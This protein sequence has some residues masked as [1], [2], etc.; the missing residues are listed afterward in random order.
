MRNGFISSLI[1]SA[2]DVKFRQ[3]TKVKH[4]ELNQFSVG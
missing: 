4:L 3:I 1:M 2:V